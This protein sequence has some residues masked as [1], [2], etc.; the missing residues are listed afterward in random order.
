MSEEN[1][2][3]VTTRTERCKQCGLCVAACPTKSIS[4]GE[5]MNS[6]GYKHT[7]INDETC[8]AC[9]V[10]YLVCPDGVYLINGD[11]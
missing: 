7:V 9:G 3:K 1:K 10:C 11:N 2:T 5:N 8:I 6:S 4:F